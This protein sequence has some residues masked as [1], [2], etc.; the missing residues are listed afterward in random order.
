MQTVSEELKEVEARLD[1]LA[2]EERELRAKLKA[3]QQVIGKPELWTVKQAAAFLS[4]PE[5]TAYY[6]AC[7]DQLPGAFKVGGRWRIRAEDIRKMAGTS[8][9]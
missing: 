9:A 6:L 7:R 8:A 2:I 5:P 4:I 3:G 1:A